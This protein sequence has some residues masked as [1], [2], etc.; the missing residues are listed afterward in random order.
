VNITDITESEYHSGCRRSEKVPLTESLIAVVQAGPWRCETPSHYAWCAL[1]SV[2]AHSDL[3]NHAWSL[4]VSL[5]VVIRRLI[6]LATNLRNKIADRG[7][8]T[9]QC[10]H[11]G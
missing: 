9:R 8:S 11:R 4:A 2:E 7:H 5:W 3:R 6:V 10:G 1:G